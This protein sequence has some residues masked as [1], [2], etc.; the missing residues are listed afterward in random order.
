[1]QLLKHKKRTPC[2]ATKT[3]HSK[4]DQCARGDIKE[5][6]QD[7]RGLRAG[8]APRPVPRPGSRLSAIINE[9]VS[10]MPLGLLTVSV[11]V[12]VSPPSPERG[13]VPGLSA[14]SSVCLQA[15]SEPHLR[16]RSGTAQ[17]H[18]ILG[19]LQPSLGGPWL[20]LSAQH[21][22]QQILQLVLVSDNGYLAQP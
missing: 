13:N 7:A 10:H 2:A 1:M 11:P 14:T 8:Q 22:R 20:E 17:V 3:R 6:Q 5:N 21:V 16:G 9:A 19:G 18:A 15:G 4:T 12:A